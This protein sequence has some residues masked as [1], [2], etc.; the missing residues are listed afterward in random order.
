RRQVSRE[1]LAGERRGRAGDRGVAR[2]PLP[3]RRRGDAHAGSVVAARRPGRARSGGVP[4]RAR[5]E[6]ATG[7]AI[8]EPLSQSAKEDDAMKSN[9]FSL[10]LIAVCALA[11]SSAAQDP[12]SSKAIEELHREVR[13]L[14]ARLRALSEAANEVAVL[15]M[16]SAA[17]W[18]RALGREA[19]ELEEAASKARPKA[20]TAAATQ[21]AHPGGPPVRQVRNRRG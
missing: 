15:T 2:S 21:S 6:P 17:I 19:K 20:S 11:A 8:P 12:S 14:E 16:R 10:T 3:L 5:V 1:Q 7:K 18:S 9:L 13:A 4:D